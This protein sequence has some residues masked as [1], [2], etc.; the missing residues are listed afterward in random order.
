MD[1]TR[2][3][4][5]AAI[6]SARPMSQAA[7]SIEGVSKSFDGGL[8]RAVTSLTLH[9]GANEFL[10][11]VGGSGSGKTTTLKMINRLVE[12]DVGVI[13]VLGRRTDAVAGHELR[14]SIGY[15][16]QGVGLFPHMTVAE[17]VAVTPKL[18]GWRRTEIVARV[19]ELLA[20]VELP[21]ADYGA[22]SPHMLSGGQRQRVGFA[23]AL[24]ARASV[25]LMDEP[26]GAL[27]PI[28]R[29]MLGQAYRRLHDAMA[30]TTVMVTHDIAEAVLLADRIG[31]MRDGELIA[32]GEPRALV[33][34]DDPCVRELFDAPLKQAADL[35]ARL[36][37]AERRG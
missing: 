27:D 7:I 1:P 2:I 32:L 34:T 37:G 9:V 8:T 30:L 3:M 25:I 17:N 35:Q 14:R 6:L 31:V 15:V 10:A 4:T 36:E 18:L 26:F 19:A 20:M 5:T 23:R 33:T 21:V 22:R 24:A 29:I 13:S 12:Q 28:T 11:L 16:F